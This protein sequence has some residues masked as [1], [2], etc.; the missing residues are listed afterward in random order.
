MDSTLYNPH[1][2]KYQ[3]IPF[4]YS[5]HISL[6]LQKKGSY[7]C[8]PSAG[9]RASKLQHKHLTKWMHAIARYNLKKFAVRLS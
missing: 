5:N 6:L 4:I 9:V 1:F 3:I 8:V 2:K 7:K